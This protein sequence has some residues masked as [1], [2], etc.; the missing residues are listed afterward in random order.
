M[1][2]SDCAAEHFDS[3]LDVGL[4]NVQ[5]LDFSGYLFQFFGGFV[6]GGAKGFFIVYVVFHILPHTHILMHP[7]P[8]RDCT[9]VVPKYNCS[10]KHSPFV[11]AS[12]ESAFG[13]NRLPVTNALREGQTI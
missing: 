8:K 11:S 5:L 7:G 12:N 9:I 3:F 13:R 10:A 2:G 4:A 6:E 1:I